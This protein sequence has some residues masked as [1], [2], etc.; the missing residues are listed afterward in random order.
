MKKKKINK[1]YIYHRD[2]EVCYYCKKT[3][4]IGKVTLDHYYPRSLGGKFDV[5]NLV[6]SCKRCNSFKKSRV[7]EDW[8][9]LNIDMFKRGIVDGF[10]NP[11]GGLSYKK[12]AIMDIVEAVSDY[13]LDHQ[14]SIFIS[15]KY[16]IYIKENKIFKIEVDP[17]LTS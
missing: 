13:E 17:D 16:R 2:G 8:K 14:F 11:I 4:H 9:A 12:S 3:L 10:I 7:P 5:F 1:R 15:G 6:A